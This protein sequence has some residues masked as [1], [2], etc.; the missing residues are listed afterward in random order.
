MNELE[1]FPDT[2]ILILDDYHLIQD[3][4]IHKSL[5]YFIEYLPAHVHL[6]IASR[7]PL[8]FATAKWTLHS[9]ALLIPANLFSFDYQETESFC[10]NII[11]RELTPQQIQQLATKTEGWAAG[12][13]LAAIS[14]SHSSNVDSFFLEFGGSHQNV[15]QFLFQEVWTSLPAEIQ[16]F[17]THTCMLSRMD[18]QVCQT[19]TGYP[20]CHEILA[21][22]QEQ[23]LIVTAL[24]Q[25]TDWYRYHHL[26]AEFLQTKLRQQGQEKWHVLYQQACECFVQRGEFGILLRWL[27]QFP[28]PEKTFSPRLAL[29][30]AFILTSSGKTERAA[31]LLSL[32]EASYPSILAPEDQEP[33]L[34]GLFFVRANLVFATGDF[35]S[36]LASSSLLDALAQ[37]QQGNAKEAISHLQEALQI[38]QKN[39]YIAVFWM[40][41]PLWSTCSWST[42]PS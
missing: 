26:F 18:S 10:R 23:N 28:K 14:L 5:S 30:Y 21:S 2:L 11:K 29:L 34:S 19:L 8:P 27:D 24:D 17:L 31:L 25:G 42:C 40:K 16:H 15:D 38:G 12:L 41:M 37:W 36:W 6:Y 20:N 7:H 33:F 4:S 13:Q 22:L 9:E 1:S 39:G 32:L 3:D 35:D